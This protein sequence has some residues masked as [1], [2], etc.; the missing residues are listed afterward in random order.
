MYTA[1]TPA[2]NR[3]LGLL[4]CFAVVCSTSLLPGSTRPVSADRP[5]AAAQSATARS[6][7]ATPNLTSHAKAGSLGARQSAARSQ[8]GSVDFGIWSFTISTCDPI[9]PVG[10]ITSPSSEDYVNTCP[11]TIPAEARDDQSGVDRVEFHGWYDGRRHLVCNDRRG[12]TIRRSYPPFTSGTKPGTRP[13]SRPA[14]RGCFN[15]GA[16]TYTFVIRTDDGMRLWVDGSLVIDAW[17]DQAPTE[18]R[19]IHSLSAGEHEVKVEYYENGGQAV[20][21]VGW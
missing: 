14:G 16:G 21:Q 3:W 10:R 4:I 8:H 2:M 11:L 13:S 19:A 12:S 20:A 5:A 15:F 9:P 6:N 1:R 18:H 7:P 17:W